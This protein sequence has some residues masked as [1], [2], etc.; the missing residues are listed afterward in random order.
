VRVENGQQFGEEGLRLLYQRSTI[1]R[2]CCMSEICLKNPHHG[3]LTADS[4]IESY[5][6][7][8]LAIDYINQHG[9]SDPVYIDYFGNRQGYRD[10]QLVLGVFAVSW[11]S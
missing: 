1:I 7:A 3:C 9:A 10:M 8:G 4:Y 5:T 6:L 2:C 11:L